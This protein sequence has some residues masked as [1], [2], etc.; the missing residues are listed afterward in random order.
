[1]G[2]IMNIRRGGGATGCALEVTGINTGDTV[3]LQ[4]GDKSYTKALDSSKKAMFRGLT[5]GT[6]TAKMSDGT[7]NVQREVKIIDNYELTM[8]FF[9]ATISVTYPVGSTC[10]CTFS[11][12]GET[13]MTYTAPDTSGS[14]TFTVSNTADWV[15]S[16]TNGTQTASKT[17]S[18][19]QDEQSES[20]VLAYQLVLYNAGDKNL[21]VTGGYDD[22]GT[23]NVNFPITEKANSVKFSSPRGYFHRWRSKNII[24]FAQI[25]TIT[26]NWTGSYFQMQIVNDTGTVLAYSRST[27]LDCSNISSGYF[28]F[29]C[30]HYNVSEGASERNCTVT[31]IIGV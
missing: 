13:I 26:A 12:E 15:V 1:M 3:L 16:C 29:G 10:T 4:K 24:D 8:K 25:S 7:Q 17:V 21:D 27:V 14:Y 11:Y 5:G 18:I 28:E 20:V 19:T 6:W 23:T 2:T 22:I 9:A 30:N 31:S